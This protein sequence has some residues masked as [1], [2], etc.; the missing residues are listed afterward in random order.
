MSKY[1]PKP[2][3]RKRSAKKAPR[4]LTSKC[5]WHL[6]HYYDLGVAMT[7]AKE[8]QCLHPIP[9]GRLYCDGHARMHN[10][11]QWSIHDPTSYAVAVQQ[12][13]LEESRSSYMGMS[14]GD[15]Q[16]IGLEETHHDRG[17]MQERIRQL[18][19]ELSYQD[20]MR[21]YG[22]AAGRAHALRRL[23]DE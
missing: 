12:R 3:A 23:T 22:T 5:T 18:Q 11:R 4:P 10:I 19:E 15:W 20:D 8:G 2:K 14:D 21:R 13:R 9:N 7:L 16:T 1:K 6:R 17:E